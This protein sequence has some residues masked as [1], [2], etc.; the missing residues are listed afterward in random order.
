MLRKKVLVLFPLAAALCCSLT[1]FADEEEKEDSD[2]KRIGL[3]FNISGGLLELNEYNDNFQSG[4]GLILHLT[5]ISSLR[6]LVDFYYAHHFL[7]NQDQFAVGASFVYEVRKP[8]SRVTPYCGA[9]AGARLLTTPEFG[10]DLYGGAIIGA[11]LSLL[12]HLSC[13]AEYG[14]T[15]DYNG[16]LIELNLGLGN[17]AQIGFI[18]YFN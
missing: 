5:D 3:I 13:F 2:K 17:N 9:I 15:L 16:A 6:A 11:E 7:L 8:F 12:D 14:L 18:I 4:L 1:A 10:Y